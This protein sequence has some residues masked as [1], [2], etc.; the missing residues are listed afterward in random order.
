MERNVLRFDLGVQRKEEDISASVRN[1]ESLMKHLCT[2]F[3]KQPQLVDMGSCCR[4]FGNKKRS[5][6]EYNRGGIRTAEDIV[7]TRHTYMCAIASTMLTF[8]CVTW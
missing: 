5:V 2:D 3:S 6:E 1:F 4:H 8:E 7:Y